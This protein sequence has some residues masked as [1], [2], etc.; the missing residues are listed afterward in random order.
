M[1]FFFYFRGIMKFTKIAFGDAV[2]VSQ[3]FLCALPSDFGHCPSVFRRSRWSDGDER[4][5]FLKSW[6]MQRLIREGEN[7]VRKRGTE[8]KQMVKKWAFR[9]SGNDKSVRRKWAQRANTN[10]HCALI[11]GPGLTQ[12]P[13]TYHRGRYRGLELYS[14]TVDLCVHRLKKTPATV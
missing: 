11:E 8:I 14:D 6:K 13:N 3:Y 2:N 5:F 1:W 7:W 10:L 4:F 9:M 12:S